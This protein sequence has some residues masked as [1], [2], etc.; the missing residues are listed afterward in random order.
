M[1]QLHRRRALADRGREALDRAGPHVAG[2]EDSRSARLEGKRRA[3]AAVPRQVEM[4]ELQLLP[5]D[6]EA[7]VVER[8][9]IAEPAVQ[10]SAPMKTKMAR[11]SRTRVVP[12]LASWIVIASRDPAPCSA[13][14][15]VNGCSR[16]RSASSIWSE[17]Y[18]D[19][20]AV[21][22]SPRTSSSTR[23]TCRARNTA[24]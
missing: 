1:D 23:P 6:D 14:T 18:R 21:R 9:R 8:D 12:V 24:A 4:R 20:V 7:V 15:S 11:A 2:G 13:T 10:G 19:M 16:M 22:S 3:V 17:T 5:G